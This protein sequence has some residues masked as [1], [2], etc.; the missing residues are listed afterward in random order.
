V[1]PYV[2]VDAKKLFSELRGLERRTRSGGKDSV[3]HGPGCHDDI[4]NAAAGACALVAQ[5][6]GW[7]EWGIR[8][9]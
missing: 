2:D 7:E 8:W 5:N 6:G 3:D 4:A 9:I 1:S